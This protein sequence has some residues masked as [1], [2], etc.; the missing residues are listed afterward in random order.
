VALESA[1][2]ISDLVATN[3]V[4]ATDTKAT[5][6]DHIRL[7]KSTVQATFPNITGAVT[8]TQTELNYVDGVT[9]AIQT[10]LDAEAASR[11]AADALKAPL[12]SPTLTGTPIAPTAATG[13]TTTQIATCEFVDNTAFAVAS[14]L[15]AASQAEMEAGTEVAQRTM[16]P[17]RV[18]QAIAAQAQFIPQFGDGSDG[19]VTVSAG[20]TTLTRNM[21]YNNLTINGTG[22]IDAAGYQIFVLGTLDLTAA[23]AGAIKRTALAGGNAV[24]NTAG[25]AGAAMAEVLAG[26]AG[27]GLVG[28]TGATGAGVASV[29]AVKSAVMLGGLSGA[30]KTAGTSS[31]AVAGG[32]GAAKPAAVSS[33][34]VLAF[35]PL[36]IAS[37]SA[38]AQG[39]VGAAGGPSGGGAGGGNPS[40][41]GGGGGTGGGVLDIRA[42]T[43]SR[44]AS[45]TAGAISVVGGAGGNGGAG[46]TGGGGGSGGAGGGGGFIQIVYSTLSGATATNALDVGGGRGGDGGAGAGGGLAGQGADGGDGGRVRFF[47]L[48]AGTVAESVSAVTGS[49]SVTTTGGAGAVAKYDL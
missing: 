11:V 1:T 44:G 17:L 15:T 3:P 43:I 33:Q 25:A 12:A 46:T 31:T 20:T 4:G 8:P 48:T 21:H 5:L 2:Y 28:K 42:S 22:S 26:G 34:S 38:L 7:V 18:A 37:A 9:S 27:I 49:A 6:D 41:G 45:T 30:T 19:D 40:G 10:Q 35:G 13:T 16:S 32:A 23:P 29:Q 24:A 39:G 47:N 14:G 36:A